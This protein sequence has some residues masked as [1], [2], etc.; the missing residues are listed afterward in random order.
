MDIESKRKYLKILELGDEASMDDIGFAYK[1]LV[2]LYGSDSSPQIEPLRGEFSEGE[3]EK[4]VDMINEAYEKLTGNKNVF[5]KDFETELEPEIINLDNENES[6]TKNVQEMKS[7]TE[8]EIDIVNEDEV[9]E[10][11]VDEVTGK[12]MKKIREEKGLKV[13][14]AAELLNISYKYIVQIENEKFEKMTDP[15][16]LRWFVSLYLKFLGINEKKGTED[17]MKR[18]R[19]KK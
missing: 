11:Y 17:Y 14:D 13:K 18:Y 15:G 2:D 9:A 16:Y 19:S 8:S 7:D 5:T 12:Y 4:I 3:R 1:Y 6:E 10:E